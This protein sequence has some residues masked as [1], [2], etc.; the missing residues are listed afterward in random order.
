MDDKNNNKIPNLVSLVT[1][2]NC[3]SYYKVAL[4]CVRQVEENELSICNV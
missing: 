2:T 1:M 4:K 3:E